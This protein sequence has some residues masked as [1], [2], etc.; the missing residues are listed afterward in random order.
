MADRLGLAWLEVYG[1][2]LLSGVVT[3]IELIVVTT[4]FS[5][6]LSVLGRPP[7]AVTLR[8]FVPRS[9]GMWS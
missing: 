2:A 8:G 4:L 7:G 5:S 6:V 9:A 3:T 1:V